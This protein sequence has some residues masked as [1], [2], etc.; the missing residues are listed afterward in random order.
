MSTNEDES[1]A[2]TEP[3]AEEPVLNR[4][5]RRALKSGKKLGARVGASTDQLRGGSANSGSRG[6]HSGVPRVGSNKGR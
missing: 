2:E 6:G 1:P 3:T 4:E 5:Q